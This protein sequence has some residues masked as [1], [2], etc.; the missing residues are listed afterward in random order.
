VIRQDFS[1][2]PQPPRPLLRRTSRPGIGLTARRHSLQFGR[3]RPSQPSAAPLRSFSCPAPKLNG[4]VALAAGHWRTGHIHLV[5]RL[6][7][8]GT[9][10]NRTR[11][12]PPRARGPTTCT[13]QSYSPP[14]ISSARNVLH[15]FHQPPEKYRC[16]STFF[17]FL[18]ASAAS[19]GVCFHFSSSRR[20]SAPESP[21]Q[22]SR[23]AVGR[24]MEASVTNVTFRTDLQ[25][26]ILPMFSGQERFRPSN[27]GGPLPPRG[28]VRCLAR[29]RAQIFCLVEPFGR[30][31]PV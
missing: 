14:G 7:G 25:S 1:S 13:R 6:G 23:T 15:S 31:I 8:I 10:A 20:A 24:W 19:F 22:F 5:H 26:D 16:S 29:G 3:P 17:L 27:Q 18:C 12:Q 9:L 21:F 30:F 2:L 11:L 4:L 28:N